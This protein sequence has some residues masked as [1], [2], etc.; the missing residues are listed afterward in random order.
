L[1]YRILYD[2]AHFALILSSASAQIVAPQQICKSATATSQISQADADSKATAAALALAQAALN[3]VQQFTSTQSYK[4]TCAANFDLGTLG[5]DVTRSATVT[6]LI[7]QQDADA[8]ALAAAKALAIAAL[9]C[10]ASNSDQQIT[11]N[12]NAVAAP[13]PSVKFVSGLTGL[14]TKVT[15]AINGLY[16]TWPSDVSM[17]LKSPAGT[18]VY[19]MGRCGGG[20]QVGTPPTGYNPSTGISLVFDDAGATALPNTLIAAG[21]YKP[22]LLGIA[23]P[24]RSPCPGGTIQATLAALIGENPNGSWALYVNDFSAVNSGIIYNGWSLTIASA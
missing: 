5:S 18:L 16:H 17:V 19:L 23:L 3:C 10:T 15:V 24:P 6:S 9:V 22:T 12:D 7:S 2:T 13:Y 21:T 4:A 20:F 14:I 8:N 1:Y 11:I